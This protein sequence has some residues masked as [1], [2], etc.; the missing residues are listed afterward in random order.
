MLTREETKLG[1]QAKWQFANRYIQT[2]RSHI[3]EFKIKALCP[4]GSA[5]FVNVH[6]GE[7]QTHPRQ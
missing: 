7:D 6:G 3:N 2:A 5:P 4:L 1:T